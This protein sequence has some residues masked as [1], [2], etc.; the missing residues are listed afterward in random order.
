[1]AKKR[2]GRWTAAR[3]AVQIAVAV[4][5]FI[6][7]FASGWGA[8]G[9]GFSSPEEPLATPDGF[10]WWGSLS[11]SRLFGLDLLDPF[12]A[13]QVAVAA[14]S[15]AF[16]GLAWA[17]PVLVVY[18]IIRGRVFCGWA[19]PVNLLCEF[20]DWLRGKSGIAVRERSVPRRAKV[21]IAAAVLAL[22]AVCS[23]PVFELVNPISA[24]N[25]AV[26][27]GSF[28]GVFTLAAIVVAE[29][30]WSRRVWCRALCP[31]GGMYE[32]LGCV[33]L[34]SVKIDHGACVHCGACQAACLCDP[35]ILDDALAG[36]TDRV[37]SGDCMLC[38]KCVDA[39]PHSALE[40]G[41]VLPRHPEL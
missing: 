25:K 10:A 23:V 6:P 8:A 40:I 29:L 12:A 35:R 27:F 3:R 13:L 16:A 19:C 24:V 21:G 36:K 33:G 15:V 11:S 31:L 41:F 5:F 17:L 30:F 34:V 18:G 28:A 1:M 22:S 37:A 32:A 9:L 20:V 4:L 38:G 7:L 26:L 14:K 2:K 39:C